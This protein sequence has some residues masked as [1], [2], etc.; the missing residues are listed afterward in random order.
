VP[1]TLRKYAPKYSESNRALWRAKCSA[2]KRS[3][4]LIGFGVL[5]ASLVVG[6]DHSFIVLHINT[7]TH[8]LNFLRVVLFIQHPST[9]TTPVVVVAVVP[10]VVVVVES[11]HKRVV[12]LLELS[13]AR[14]TSLGET[15]THT[16]NHHHRWAP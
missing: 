9:T 6:S 8:I 12:L 10:V 4:A 13:G 2:C 15:Q 3:I 11:N 14:S 1:K 7:H 16:D 5:L